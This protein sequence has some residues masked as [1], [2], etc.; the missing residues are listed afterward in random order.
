V[1]KTNVKTVKNFTAAPIKPD[2]GI[3]LDT[4]SQDVVKSTKINPREI[5]AINTYESKGIN[6]AIASSPIPERSDLDGS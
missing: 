5:K 4:P 3:K 2:T 6:S 1:Q